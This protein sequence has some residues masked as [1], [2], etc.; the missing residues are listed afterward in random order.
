[1]SEPVRRLLDLFGALPE[2]EQRSALNEILRQRPAGEDSITAAG[3]DY[4]ADELFV[5]LDA[6]EAAS[7]KG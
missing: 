2:M 5:G 7:A 4:L 6:E 1:M 3:L